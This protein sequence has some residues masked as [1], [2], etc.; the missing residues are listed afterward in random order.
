MDVSRFFM[1]RDS[2]ELAS[3]ETPMSLPVLAG[4]QY[5]LTGFISRRGE[6][7]GGVRTPTSLPIPPTSREDLRLGNV[8][9]IALCHKGA[10]NLRNIKASPGSTVYGTVVPTL[11]STIRMVFQ[12]MTISA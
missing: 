3:R 8:F 6:H 4:L 1:P 5:N 12:Q 9:S 10:I 2:R 11:L 7:P